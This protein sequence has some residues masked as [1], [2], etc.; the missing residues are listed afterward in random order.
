MLFASK[1]GKD[2]Y[3]IHANISPSFH[4]RIRCFFLLIVPL[5]I[6]RLWKYIQDSKHGEE[7]LKCHFELNKMTLQIIMIMI[8]SKCYGEKK[9]E[10]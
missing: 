6:R 10:R 8:E 3:L 9:N 1:I 5:R 4:S 2:F 7:I